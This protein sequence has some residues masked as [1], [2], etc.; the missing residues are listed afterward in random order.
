MCGIPDDKLV[1]AH[2]SFATASC[3]LCYTAYPA[4]E[5]KHAIMN[6]NVPICTFCAATVKPDVVFFGEDLP[7]KYFLHTKDFPK[8]DLLIIMGTSLQIEPFASLV[9]TVRSTVPRLLLNRH[10]VGPF[11][12]VPRRRGDHMELGDLEDTVR[13]FAEILGWSDEIEEL[14]GSQETLS[15]PTLISNPLSVS[16]QTP[17]QSRGASE[18][19]GR[20]ETSRPG[21]QRVASSGSEETDSETDSKSSASS[22]LSN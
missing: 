1:E 7:Q 16:V 10:A 13:R 14:M 5:A 22:N 11:E 4:E 20:M 9:N 17:C 8:A 3:H 18:P 6:D 21:A 12:K 15:I 19:P 2:G